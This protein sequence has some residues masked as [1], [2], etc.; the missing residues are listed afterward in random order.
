MGET[1][2]LIFEN[3]S[4]S[5]NIL[6]LKV[7][8]QDVFTPALFSSAEL[9]PGGFILS[10]LFVWEGVNTSVAL[11]GP[12]QPD[13]VLAEEVVRVRFYTHSVQFVYGENM[14]QTRSD[15]TA[16]RISA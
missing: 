4:Y 13:R 2:G 10:V 11:C 12:R 7:A 3:K 15:P 6:G 9:D 16:G 5:Q 14:I 1:S 8:P